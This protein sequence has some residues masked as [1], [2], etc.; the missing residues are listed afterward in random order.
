MK[1]LLFQ[2]PQAP[3][4][5]HG[6]PSCHL[7]VIRKALEILSLSLPPPKTHMLYI[8]TDTTLIS[9]SHSLMERIQLS[10]FR[11]KMLSKRVEWAKVV[12]KRNSDNK[13]GKIIRAR[14]GRWVGV[15]QNVTKRSKKKKKHKRNQPATAYHSQIT[16]CSEQTKKKKGKK[17]RIYLHLNNV[18]LNPWSATMAAYGEAVWCWPTV[19]AYIRK[20]PHIQAHTL[21]RTL[22]HPLQ[23][24]MRH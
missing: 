23:C 21:P 7:S 9:L 6:I 18:G 15:K 4:D 5:S 22:V 11:K 14:E 20:I 13:R 2:P 10:S 12:C 16:L 24:M 8:H 19:M 1:P 17:C 3:L